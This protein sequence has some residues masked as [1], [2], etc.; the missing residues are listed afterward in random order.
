MLCNKWGKNEI[1]T[2]KMQI[3]AVKKMMYERHNSTT[4]KNKIKM[5]YT[6]RERMKDE[7]NLPRP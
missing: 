3:I 6:K 2:N 1:K 5:N 4:T 7:S